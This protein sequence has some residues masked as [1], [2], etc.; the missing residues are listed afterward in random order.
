MGAWGVGDIACRISSYGRQKNE[1]P[2]GHPCT[3]VG[4]VRENMRGRGHACTSV[5]SVRENMRDRG[6]A[7][8]SVGSVR[9]NMRG[10]G[11]ACT[12]VGSVRENMQGWASFLFKR[13]ERSLRS[14][15]FF[16]KE[17]NDLC[18]LFRSF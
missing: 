13:T 4:S 15:P 9:E 6:H 2:R 11:H 17:R 14:F 1:T 12:S 16:I 5:G 7:C 18:V 10:G 3:S 8:M